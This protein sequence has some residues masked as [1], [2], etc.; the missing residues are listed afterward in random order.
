MQLYA[1]YLAELLTD[2]AEQCFS[3]AKALFFY[4]ECG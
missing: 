2:L 1:K 4:K 3:K